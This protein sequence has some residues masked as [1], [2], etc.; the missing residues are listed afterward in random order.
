MVFSRRES[1]AVCLEHSDS[2]RTPRATSKV[3][4]YYSSYTQVVTLFRGEQP[5]LTPKRQSERD[6]M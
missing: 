5:P 2:L 6:E 4:H 3:T 1:G